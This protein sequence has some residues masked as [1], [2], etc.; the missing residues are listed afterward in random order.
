MPAERLFIA[1]ELPPR[2]A[3]EL[4]WW[5]RDTC[6]SDPALRLLPVG[7]LHLTLAFLGKRSS[8][9]VPAVG[10][11]LRSVAGAGVHAMDLGWDDAI[12]LPE[13]R[14]SVLAMRLDDPGA[15]LGPLRAAVVAAVA[16]AVGWEPEARPFLAHVSV[17]RVR[18]GLRPRTLDLTLP[19]PERF[20]PAA[21]TLFRSEPSPEGPVSTPLVAVASQ[22]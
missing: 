12:W 7:S 18:A 17:A 22:S 9:D 5:A 20:A 2:V 4:A 14:P 1:A 19:S 16:S 21:V 6:G 8:E 13:R 3:E 15:A 10:E 11:A